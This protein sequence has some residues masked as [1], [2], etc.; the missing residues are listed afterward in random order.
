MQTAPMDGVDERLGGATGVR[1]VGDE[2]H[3]RTGPWTPAVQALMAH[4][5]AN[6][7]RETPEVLGFDDAGD[8]VLRFVPGVNAAGAGHLG[9]ARLQA[10]GELLGRLRCALRSFPAP[11]GRTWRPVAGGS[12]LAHGDVAPWNL[13]FDGDAVAALLD[14][15]FAGPN[16][17][18][19]DV[20]YAAWTC[21]PLEPWS[22]LTVDEVAHRLRLLVDA[23]GLGA[24]ERRG[25]LSTIAYSQSRVT[26]Q[27]AHGAVT[28]ELGI[29]G[30][31][32]S[33]RHL[34]RIGPAMSWLD[35]HWDDLEA[36]LR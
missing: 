24:E 5:R 3:R 9:E 28:G 13:V 2:V 16:A 21:V 20:A 27:V 22:E 1:I 29:P 15:D 32:R 23:A 19:Y 14:W 11:G 8:E 31:W 26:F 30:I 4:A 25:L 35:A 6:G 10:V 36:A 12:E 34:G 17:P 18:A 7:V 33:G